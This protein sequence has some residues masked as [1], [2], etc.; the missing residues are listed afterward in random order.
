MA[1]PPGN[2]VSIPDAGRDQIARLDCLSSLMT[3]M[4]RLALQAPRRLEL[5]FPHELCLVA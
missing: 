1:R 4:T 5:A 2:G 3:Q